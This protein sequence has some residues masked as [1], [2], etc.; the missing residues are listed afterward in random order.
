MPK[1][2][3]LL[4]YT[5]SDFV[6][7]IVPCSNFIMKDPEARNWKGFTLRKNQFRVSVVS[8]IS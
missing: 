1:L 5:G 7:A 8:L 2:S 6:W 4:F 3:T